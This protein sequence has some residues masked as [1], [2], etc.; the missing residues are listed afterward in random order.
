M[1]E[2]SATVS[3]GTLEKDV[4]SEKIAAR[5][6]SLI[7]E[8]QL[9]SGEKLPPERDL[10][11]MLQVSRSSLREALRALAIIGAVETRQGNG[12]YVTSLE[13]ELLVD[14]LE[15]VVSLN[16]STFAHLFEARKALELGIVTMAAQKIT[17]AELAVME[18][19]LKRSEKTDEGYQAFL[20]A[21]LD[22]HELIA[23]AAHNPIFESPYMASIRRLGRAS[24]DRN[25]QIPGLP[26]QSFKDHRVILASLKA[27]DPDAAYAAML[28]HLTNVEAKLM[29]TPSPTLMPTKADSAPIVQTDSDSPHTRSLAA[30]TAALRLIKSKARRPA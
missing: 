16:D 28:R 10:A 4:L 5:L 3:F 22:F 7:K 26:E 1:N 17:D 20:Q 18:V 23:Q 2:L 6:L 12:T 27:R 24:R 13:P 30:P 21:D 29:A 25:S 19:C 11:G 8:R 9:H 15:Y 14:H